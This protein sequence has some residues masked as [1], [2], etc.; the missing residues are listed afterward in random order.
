MQQYGQ[1]DN[2]RLRR[3]E[4]NIKVTEMCNIID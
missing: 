3:Y 2:N 1:H 4:E